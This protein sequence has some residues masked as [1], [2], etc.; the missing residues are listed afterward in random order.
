MQLLW[1]YKFWEPSDAPHQH[2]L[3]V[4]R[5]SW[6]YLLLPSEQSQPELQLILSWLYNPC[7]SLN[8]HF[9]HAQKRKVLPRKTKRMRNSRENLKCSC[10]S[11]CV[12]NTWGAEKHDWGAFKNWS[13]IMCFL[14]FKGHTLTFNART[15]TIIYLDILTSSFQHNL[16]CNWTQ[17]AINQTR[18]CS[19][20]TSLPKIPIRQT[21]KMHCNLH[22]NTKTF[23][24]LCT[25]TLALDS[26]FV[27]PHGLAN[28][29]VSRW[30]PT[31]VCGLAMSS[32]KKTR[33]VL[34]IRLFCQERWLFC[35]C[36]VISQT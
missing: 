10:I 26:Y 12:C 35:V 32:R 7:L 2:F 31:N 19:I 15:C 6:H 8:L 20:D 24:F 34:E 23:I 14:H 13:L 25:V 16:L 18:K 1:T 22:G 27:H 28:V 3:F 4:M 33:S 5:Q 17:E 9:K 11:L 21:W 29:F 30:R 36:V